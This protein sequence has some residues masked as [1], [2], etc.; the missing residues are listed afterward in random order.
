MCIIVPW[1]KEQWLAPFIQ[2]PIQSILQAK[3]LLKSKILRE[4]S[5]GL[6]KFVSKTFLK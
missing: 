2:R 1:W 5:V 6:Q 4:Y 3:Q